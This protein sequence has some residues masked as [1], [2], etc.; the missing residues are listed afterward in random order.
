MKSITT[1][2]LFFSAII[3]ATAQTNQTDSATRAARESARTELRE[4][5]QKW[6]RSSVL[7]TIAE[8]KEEL[9][10]GM[11]SADLQTLNELRSQAK[12]LR[13]K[14]REHMQGLSQAWKS[15]DEASIRQHRTALSETRKAWLDI[16]DELEPLAFRYR[17]NLKEIATK[18]K[19]IVQ[20]WRKE[21]K[22]IALQWYEEHSDILN[23]DLRKI[24]NRSDIPHKW[25]SGTDLKRKRVARFMLWDGDA[26]FE[27]GDTRQSDAPDL[28]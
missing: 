18:A 22:A 26:L 11:S 25:F 16:V 10:R 15:E 2:L 14:V 20:K 24:L 17:E 23:N 4:R 28:R 6:A 21:G 19:P 27:E 12:Q 7:P 8:W 3:V 1:T 13:G 5:L 9:D